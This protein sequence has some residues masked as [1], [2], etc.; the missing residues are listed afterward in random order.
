M[1]DPEECTAELLES[2]SEVASYTELEAAREHALV[3]LATRQACWIVQDGDDAGY[4]LLVEPDFLARSLAE[5]RAYDSEKDVAPR[6]PVRKAEG[7][8]H[9]PGYGAIAAWALCLT[10]VFILQN[11]IPGLVDLGASS[12]TGL[13]DRH[14]WWRP[15]TGLFLHADTSHLAGNLLAGAFFGGLVSRLVGSR[16]GW[17][18]ILGCGALGNS[19]TSLLTHPAPFTSI[20][21]STAVFAALGILSGH[22]FSSLIRH[23]MNLSLMR[24]SAPVLGGIVVLGLMGGAAPDGHTDVPGHVCGFLAGLACG[25]L[26]ALLSRATGDASSC[27][28]SKVERD[29]RI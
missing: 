23:R 21:A 1:S 4:R 29:A 20:G 3:V 6:E 12:S 10:L 19:L 8:R 15:V 27:G 17:L 22:G 2:L 14:E 13:I 26:T 16:S 25:A 9:A 18:M 5:I 24:V 7:F 11:R 28:I